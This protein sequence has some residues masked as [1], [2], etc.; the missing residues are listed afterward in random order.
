[1][2][3]SLRDQAY[4]A[5]SRSEWDC[6]ISTWEQIRCSDHDD[7]DVS[8]ALAGCLMNLGRLDEAEAE[9]LQSMERHRDHV[10]LAF[11][12]AAI[13]QYRQNVPGILDRWREVRSRFPEHSGP[14]LEPAVCLE[15]LGRLT[16]A[17]ALLA[18]GEARFPLDSAISAAAASLREKIG[19]MEL[20]LK[21]QNLGGN[22]EFALVQRH[23]CAE[24]VSLFRWA[25]ISVAN[26]I[27][28]LNTGLEGIGSPEYTVL[29][30]GETEYG[31]SDRRY[32]MS[33]HTF[34]SPEEDYDKIF[35]ETCD[36]LS[37]L[38]RQ[39]ID[40]IEND[41]FIFVYQSS[42]E[43]EV[44]IIDDLYAAM[45][46]H[47]AC[48]LLFVTVEDEKHPCG[49]LEVRQPGLLVGRIDKLGLHTEQDG[50]LVWDISFHIWLDLCKRAEALFSESAAVKARPPIDVF[51][52]EATAAC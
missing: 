3:L 29:F 24:T 1:M 2:Q 21:F 52:G 11:S 44:A 35:S 46:R 14:F 33:A 27:T 8:T 28:A 6:A 17:L 19:P 10:P 12:Y 51:Q 13:M 41:E 31:T 34:I 43:D 7:P 40:D 38:S 20:L 26:L 32:G 15:R 5:M 23:F 47:G 48:R 30:K 36:R 37:Y 50:R 42:K 39:L 49:E 16:E 45:R 25:G 22:C 18:E 9:L 4:A